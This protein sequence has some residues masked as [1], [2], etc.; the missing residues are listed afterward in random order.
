[1]PCTTSYGAHTFLTLP[2]SAI[3]SFTNLSASAPK[4]P[5]DSTAKAISR[6]GSTKA[7]AQTH[8]ITLTLRHSSRALCSPSSRAVEP[9]RGQ[10]PPAIAAP[11]GSTQAPQNQ[12][13]PLLLM[14]LLLE[15]GRGA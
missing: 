2:P 13:C 1:M 4:P 15:P 9:R 5:D 6:A 3:S 8:Y 11:A 14:L 12:L 10:F 7:T